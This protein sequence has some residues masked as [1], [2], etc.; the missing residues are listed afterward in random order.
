MRPA[1]SYIRSGMQRFKTRPAVLKAQAANR[2]FR[3]DFIVL[4]LAAFMYRHPPT[5][6]R[7]C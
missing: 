5:L 4:P 7:K 6:R 2:S 3:R 1:G